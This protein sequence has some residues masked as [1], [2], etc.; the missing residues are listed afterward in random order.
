MWFQNRRAKWRKAE[1]ATVPTNSESASQGA[2][3]PGSS[4]NSPQSIA[5]ETSATATPTEKPNQIAVATPAVTT[6]HSKTCNPP[7]SP[8]PVKGEVD[9]WTHSPSNSYGSGFQS[10]VNSPS[11]VTAVIQRTHMPY[12]T[13]LPLSMMGHQS[14]P[15]SLSNGGYVSALPNYSPQC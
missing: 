2:S 12:S 13:N 1:K 6:S 4:A 5:S 7:N 10:P 15:Y 11:S 14:T 3:S 8:S 9:R